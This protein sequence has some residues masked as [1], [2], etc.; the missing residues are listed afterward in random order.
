MSKILV[1][2]CGHC[3]PRLRMKEVLAVLK[4]IDGDNTY[5]FYKDGEEGDACL[6]LCG[7]QAQ[8]ATHGFLGKEIRIFPQIGEDA[9]SVAKRILVEF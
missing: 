6:V 5:E 3:N 4:E 7:C 9:E 1:K 8:C 2:Y